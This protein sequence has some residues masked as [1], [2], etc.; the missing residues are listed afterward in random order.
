MNITTNATRRQNRK[1]VLSSA[2][3]PAVSKLFKGAAI[4]MLPALVACGG[5]GGSTDSASS[6]GAGPIASTPVNPPTP[7][8]VNS[9]AELPVAE[10][11]NLS[12]QTD[13]ALAVNLAQL[14]SHR[15]YLSVCTDFEVTNGDVNYV[16]YD[17]CLLRTWVED[18][19]YIQ[20]L[21]VTNDTQTLI[22]AVWYPELASVE[23]SQWHRDSGMQWVVN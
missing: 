16:N 15:G 19:D 14:N 7:I 11:F 3:L 22:A 4:L 23:Y 9:T 12:T 2:S 17:S 20:S 6:S 18:S 13:L 8:V 10:G 5:G 1:A 21:T